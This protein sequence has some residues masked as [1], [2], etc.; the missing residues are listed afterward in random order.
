M[1]N[2]KNRFLKKNILKNSKFLCLTSKIEINTTQPRIFSKLVI[3]GFTHGNT[4]YLSA[5]SSSC[6][7]Y[8]TCSSICDGGI[9]FHI[10]ESP[11][12]CLSWF[13]SAVT[14]CCD[15]PACRC[16]EFC[17]T[18]CVSSCMLLGGR[19][20]CCCLRPCKRTRESFVEPRCRQALHQR[21][22]W[23]ARNW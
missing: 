8:S 11:S 7:S 22:K 23:T 18:L 3:D 14:S 17:W 20:E 16:R 9:G 1:L 19:V 21:R 4:A 5:E 2:L 13:S 15:C 6:F 10:P 12:W